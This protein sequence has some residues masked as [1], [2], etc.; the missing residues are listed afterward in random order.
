MKNVGEKP[1]HYVTGDVECIDA[2]RAACSA[3]GF[4]GHLKCQVMKYVWRYESKGTPVRDL[5]KALDYLNWLH[6]FVR[7]EEQ[8][9]KADIAAYQEMIARSELMADDG[10]RD[11]QLTSRLG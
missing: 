10:W 1:E 3:E 2:Q 6:E 11:D 8:K 9:G 4:K 5:E 7:D